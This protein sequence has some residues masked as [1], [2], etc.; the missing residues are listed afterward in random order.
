M[1]Q[2]LSFSLDVG[3]ILPWSKKHD[4]FLPAQLS[5]TWSVGSCLQLQLWWSCLVRYTLELHFLL[6]LTPAL[7]DEQSSSEPVQAAQLVDSTA[8]IPPTSFFVCST[9]KEHKCCSC[10]QEE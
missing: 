5:Q 10:C 9:P 6:P 4:A 8:S 2:E 1:K 7:V 3:L